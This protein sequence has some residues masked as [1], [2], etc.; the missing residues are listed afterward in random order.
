MPFLRYLSIHSFSKCNPDW[1]IK[2]YV[3]RT[4]TQQPTWADHCCNK[5]Y[6]AFEN[7]YHMLQDI[8]NLEIIEFDSRNQFML[9]ARVSEVHKSDI[10][11]LWV[12]YDQ[13][14]VWSDID[15]LYYKPIESLADVLDTDTA[16]LCYREGGVGGPAYH[17]I[18]LLF[19]AKHNPYF[20]TLFDHFR[21]AFDFRVYQSV[22]SYYYCKHFTPDHN[23]FHDDRY[24]GLYNIDI[25]VVYPCRCPEMLFKDKAD[26]V[27][28]YL[29]P[30]TIG[31]HWYGGAPV[32]VEYQSIM[33][34]RSWHV[35]DNIIS[36][37]AKEHIYGHC[38]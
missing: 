35:V 1:Q 31:L 28:P 3:A 16:G 6:E 37:L 30:H 25:E 24:P 17:S 5:G 18:G 15:I 7:C 27:K 38:R 32:A 2:L 22:G 21:E 34:P 12:L 13:G 20:K 11:R 26:V 10:L 8:P 19:G 9:D 33:G 36:Y 23:A 29:K 4:L 14:G